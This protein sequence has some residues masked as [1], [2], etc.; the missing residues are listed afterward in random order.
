M[1]DTRTDELISSLRSSIPLPS[2]L[3]RLESSLTRT[4]DRYSSLLGTPHSTSSLS[5]PEQSRRRIQS[6]HPRPFSA[7]LAS[8]SINPLLPTP[9]GR[10]PPA[11]PPNRNATEPSPGDELPTY[12]RRA[13]TNACRPASYSGASSIPNTRGSHR[14][15]YYSTSAAPNMSTSRAQSAS[16]KPHIVTSSSGKIQLT[17]F[18]PSQ[19]RYPVLLQG[20]D[21]ELQGELK[22]VLG[23]VGESFSEIRVKCKGVVSTLVVRAQ[24]NNA[25]N[26]LRDETVFM[27]LDQSLYQPPLLSTLD[28]KL[29]GT[30]TFPFKFSLPTTYANHPVLPPS[31]AL[32]SSMPDPIASFTRHDMPTKIIEWASIKYYVKVTLARRG[33]LR[34][35][36]RLLAPF[37]LL[38]RPSQPP[39]SSFTRLAAQNLGL[40]FPS[41]MED[42]D[43]WMGRKIRQHIKLPA[44]HSSCEQGRTAWYEVMVLLPSPLCYARNNPLPYY[45]KF[46][47][48]DPSITTDFSQPS[49]KVSLLQRAILTALGVSGTHENSLAKGSSRPDGPHG[50]IHLRSD[51][52]THWSRRYQG[53]LML[54]SNAVP[55]FSCQNI[56]IQYYFNLTVSVP[57]QSS[58]LHI[59]LPIQLVSAPRHASTPRGEQSSS[60]DAT[61]TPSA[62]PTA[63]AVAEDLPPSYWD[64]QE[65][66]SHT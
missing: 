47:S 11:R 46:T 63:A 3:D 24:G 45:I 33:L 48:S 30:M 23:D 16:L 13:P 2:A 43:G 35:N 36:D 44:S 58:D 10:S 26:A 57:N 38:S 42:P 50:G 6:R 34:T 54:V 37:V 56:A 31:F 19:A 8:P 60:E 21:D 7:F 25:G 53:D 29:S 18:S 55:N 52:N 49:F 61:S 59:S 41:P 4:M 15:P 1:L 9:A 14:M 32:T 51:T 22:L 66:D 65:M 17:L 40:P 28:Q 39:E 5:S 64:V 20:V 27:Q 12:T 62:V